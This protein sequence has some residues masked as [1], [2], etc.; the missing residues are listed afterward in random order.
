MAVVNQMKQIT[1]VH[2]LNPNRGSTLLRKKTKKGWR[3]NGTLTF[4]NIFVQLGWVAD[5][6]ESVGEP[7]VAAAERAAVE[8]VARHRRQRRAT[9]PPRQLP[10]L[11]QQVG[12]TATLLETRCSKDTCHIRKPTP[13][14]KE[15]QKCVAHMQGQWLY[16]AGFIF[17]RLA[18]N[19]MPKKPQFFAKLN[20]LTKLN[21]N[22]SKNSIFRDFLLHTTMCCLKF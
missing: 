3:Q 11:R 18:Q 16:N 12:W 10:Q 6:C 20:F 13:V 2:Y 5:L 4:G 15:K 22:L 1:S 7:A 8:A 17:V 21:L 9:P 19:W 14:E